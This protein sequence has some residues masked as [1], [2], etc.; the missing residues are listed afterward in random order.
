M[1]A[2]SSSLLAAPCKALYAC[3]KDFG[4]GKK[5]ELRTHLNQ[6]FFFGVNFHGVAKLAMIQTG[7]GQED[8]TKFFEQAKYETNIF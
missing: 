2:A 7:L 6:C 8:W 5:L 3:R 1:H 4:V